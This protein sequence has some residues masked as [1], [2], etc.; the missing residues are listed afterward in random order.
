MAKVL[1]VLIP[2]LITA[3]NV[4]MYISLL[5]EGNTA[6]VRE[7]LPELVSK[8]PNDPDVMY[9]KALMTTD[10]M[11]ALEQ[12]S[13]LLDKFPESKYAPDAA[14]K[15]GEYFY[16]RGLYTQASSYLSE[17]LTQYPNYPNVQ[18]VIDLMVSSFQATGE[19]DSA[20]Y[21]VYM[22]KS[23]FPGLDV[24]EYG[25]RD[26]ERRMEAAALS[27]RVMEQ[28]HYVVQ[29]GAFG[30]NANAKRLKLQVSQIGYSVIVAPVETNGRNLHAVRVVGYSSKKAAD[31]AGRDIKK[32]LG[33][34]YRVLY[35]PK[36]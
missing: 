36:S 27:S 16:A 30:S 15:I 32:K 7:Q 35:R 19:E 6:G 11:A 23:M 5:H 18:R 21:Y 4:D 17:V 34:D 8:F 20:K 9:L 22:Y 29:I 28:K 31:Q 1:I 13:N 2:L 10:G 33:I 24:S 26:T 12:Y 3:Q 14:I 25:Y